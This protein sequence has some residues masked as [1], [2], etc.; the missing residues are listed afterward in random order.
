MMRLVQKLP[1]PKNLAIGW[2]IGSQC[3]SDLRKSLHE[4]NIV[5]SEQSPLTVTIVDIQVARKL[6]GVSED[7]PIILIGFSAGCQSVR[8]CLLGN[9]VEKLAGVAVFDGT[10]GAVPP[11]DWQINV[12]KNIAVKARNKELIFIATCSN[13]NYTKKIPIGQ[14]GRATPTREILESVL[15]VTL[16]PDSEVFQDGLIFAKCYPSKSLDKE[17]HI[18]QQRV[19][20]PDMLSR[21]MNFPE[22][23]TSTIQTL[24]PNTETPIPDLKPWKD[25]YCSFR[26]RCLMWC[27]NELASNV[28]EIPPGSN[29]GPRI[30]EYFSVP[31]F[32]RNGNPLHISKSPWCASAQCCAHVECFLEGD[33]PPPEARVSGIELEND[34]KR[35]GKLYTGEPQPGDLAIFKRGTG[36]ERHVTRV[37]SVNSEDRTFTT[38]GGNEDNT[39]KETVHEAFDPLLTGFIQVQ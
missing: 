39:W 25:P 5:M 19:V 2:L 22:N 6:S 34:A 3:D 7:I 32:R 10:H 29:D 35:L 23:E 21:F 36:W 16:N 12:W 33:N 37:K 13:M 31:S 28:Q 9:V 20:M 17:A 8:A 38:L 15:N 11:L 26:H 18:Y 4:S 14:P 24:R 30:R 1:S 27:E